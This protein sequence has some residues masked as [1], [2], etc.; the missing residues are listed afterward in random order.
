M[1][2]GTTAQQVGRPQPTTTAEAPGGP[3]I[4]HTQ[5]GSGSQ[6]MQV[7]AAFAQLVQQP[8][9]SRPGYYRDFRVLFQSTGGANGGPATV[10]FTA[11]GV[12]AIA[13]LIQVRDPFGTL[14]YSLPSFEAYLQQLHSGGAGIGLGTAS[15]PAVLPGSYSAVAGTGNAGNFSWALTLPFEFAKGIGTMVG[16]NAS[17]Q[18]QLMIQLNP[19][20]SV[21]STNPTTPPTAMTVQLESEF[22]WL[23]EASASIEP[24]GIGTSR[25][26][27]LQQGTQSISASSTNRIGFPRLG[28]YID[29]IIIEARDSTGARVDIFPGATVADTTRIR[30][31]IDGVPIKDEPGWEFTD[32][33][34]I[35][36]GGLTRPTGVYAWTRKTSL[37]QRNE[38]LLDTGE[39]TLSTNPGTLIELEWVTGA[40]THS[41][42]TLYVILGQI[43]PRGPLAQGLPEL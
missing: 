34:Y 41:P 31:Y 6:W 24:P 39:E 15:N 5:P 12:F 18:A 26:F 11:D 14:I 10:A 4:R 3:F 35:A 33:Y 43:V 7:G 19:L 1:G 27:V 13:S 42:A 32:N 38:G 23:P 29:T 17:L 40:I 36:F 25:Q 9:V 22:Y 21:F 37:N 2:P 20:A 8:L 28:G 30:L 16:A